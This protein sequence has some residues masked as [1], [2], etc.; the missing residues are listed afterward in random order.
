MRIFNVDV[1]PKGGLNAVSCIVV[2]RDTSA[3]HF[4]WFYIEFN[5]MVV[6][7]HSNLESVAWRRKSISGVNHLWGGVL[8]KLV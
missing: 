7:M 8:S 5:G 2:P 4:S 3:V 1:G 6:G